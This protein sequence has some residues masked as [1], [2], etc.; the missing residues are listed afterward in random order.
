MKTSK[1]VAYMNDTTD[2]Q[3]MN[4]SEL[5]K[6]KDIELAVKISPDQQQSA[7]EWISF[8]LGYL[9]P[10]TI[11]MPYLA[12]IQSRYD[13]MMKT[14]K[15]ED[16]HFE[17]DLIILEQ[18]RNDDMK[19]SGW[20]KNQFSEVIHQYAYDEIM[21]MYKHRARELL[22]RNM[23]YEPLVEHSFE[24]EIYLRYLFTMEDY[25]SGIKFSRIEMK[26]MAI[27]QYRSEYYLDGEKAADKSDLIGLIY[28]TWK[29][30]NGYPIDY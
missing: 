10:Q 3:G 21:P 19:K 2:D 5:V 12:I 30:D 22:C 29:K 25:H 11:Y 7:L 26:A 8:A 16:K 17:E 1:L 6:W 14:E 28:N 18:I 24:A 15:V 9:P 20:L 13:I 4:Y 23:G 27:A